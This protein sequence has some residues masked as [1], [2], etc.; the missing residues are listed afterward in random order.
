[1]ENFFQNRKDYNSSKMTVRNLKEKDKKHLFGLFFNLLSVK[2]YLR[3]K[4]LLF[5]G[6]SFNLN[7]KRFHKNELK[8]ISALSLFLLLLLLFYVGNLIQEKYEM[9]LRIMISWIKY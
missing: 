8:Y 2:S 9:N 6:K 4:V 3:E 1:M 7:W 5:A